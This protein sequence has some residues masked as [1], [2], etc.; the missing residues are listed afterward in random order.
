MPLPPSAGITRELH[1][2]LSNLCSGSDTGTHAHAT[3]NLL[4]EGPAHN[5]PAF[6]GRASISFTP[7]ED[8]PC[9]GNLNLVPLHYLE[10][11]LLKSNRSSR[12][13]DPKSSS[14]TRIQ[15][16]LFSSVIFIIGS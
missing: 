11:V 5:R 4:T 6:E 10:E 16:F 9:L 2:W 7:S 15:G 3:R 1:T 13:M 8:H 12:F 14:I